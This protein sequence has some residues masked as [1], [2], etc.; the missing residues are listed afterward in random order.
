MLIRRFRNN[1]TGGFQK[2]WQG[3]EIRVINSKAI[4]QVHERSAKFF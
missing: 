2:Y 3:T 4:G 1:E